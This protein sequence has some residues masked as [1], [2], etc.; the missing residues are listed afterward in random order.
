MPS[1]KEVKEKKI[2]TKKH[3]IHNK[4]RNKTITY[5]NSDIEENDKNELYN[6]SILK[7]KLKTLIDKKLSSNKRIKIDLSHLANPTAN[8]DKDI[9]TGNTDLELY[10][11]S[12][13]NKYESMNPNYKATQNNYL[14]DEQKYQLYMNGITDQF[15]RYYKDIGK[16]NKPYSNYYDDPVNRT[17]VYQGPI[18]FQDDQGNWINANNNP[19]FNN[20]LPINY[21]Q[22]GQSPGQYNATSYVNNQRW[23]NVGYNNGYNEEALEEKRKNRL[24]QEDNQ[25]LKQKIDQMS[26]EQ[27]QWFSNR[28]FQWFKDN[29]ITGAYDLIKWG[30]GVIMIAFLGGSL[31]EAMCWTPILGQFGRQIG[32]FVI[33]HTGIMQKLFG[34]TDQN[35]RWASGLY[36]FGTGGSVIHNFWHM[37]HNWWTGQSGGYEDNIFSTVYHQFGRL[38]DWCTNFV[39][40]WWNGHKNTLPPNSIGPPPASTTT[41]STGSG[42]APP[43]SNQASHATPTSS[44]P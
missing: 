18:F 36:L 6:P 15:G 40:N 38:W 23:S 3:K 10:D 26:E 22:N 43:H 44:I 25:K 14:S 32:Q 1:I 28:V 17:S 37:L 7:Q 29:H 42:Q 27:K 2:R 9:S 31:I 20:N 34:F 24:W 5:E 12:L 19:N 30:I 41:G 8:V 39:S 11:P 4:K 13:I 21:I 16:F 35:V 33:F